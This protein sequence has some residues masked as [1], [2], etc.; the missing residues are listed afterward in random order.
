[1]S[2]L[3]A[4]FIFSSIF[5]FNLYSGDSISKNFSA[6]VTPTATP[7]PQISAES[8]IIELDRNLVILPS[9]PGYRCIG[10]SDENALVTVTI[11]DALK[12]DSLKYNYTLSGGRIMAKARK[13]S[14]I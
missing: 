14:G 4:L 8:N 2:K 12:N 9:P 1:M 7:T 10:T 11:S 13:F 6:I 3:L 5:F